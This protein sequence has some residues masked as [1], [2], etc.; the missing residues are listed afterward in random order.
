MKQ[1]A[2]RFAPSGG[3]GFFKSDSAFFHS[4]TSG[5][6]HGRLSDAQLAAYDAMMDAHLSAEDRS[7]LENGA[8]TR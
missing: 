7:W 8:A 5:K 1:N 4:G 6:W 2:E 3:K